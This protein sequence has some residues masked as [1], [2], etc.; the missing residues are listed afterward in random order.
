MKQPRTSDFRLARIFLRIAVCLTALASAVA[1]QET[2]LHTFG[3]SSTDGDVPLAGLVSDASGNL[4]GTTD[5]GGAPDVGTVFELVRSNGGTW[6]EKLIHVFNSNGRDGNAPQATL[7]FDKAGNLYGTTGSGGLYGHGT[8]FEL[9]PDTNGTWTEK[10]L[11]NFSGKDGVL[12]RASLIFDK[13]GNLYGTTDQGG[14]TISSSLCSP[15]GCGTVFEL[16]HR[17]DGS[18]AEKVLHNFDFNGI[19]GFAPVAS[20]AFDSAG[21]LYGTAEEGGA[22]NFGILFELTPKPHGEWTETILHNFNQDGTDGIF[23]G[24]GLFFDASGN[25]Y[26]TTSGGGPGGGGT[27]FE[28]SPGSNGTWT[29]TFLH[30]FGFGTDG[31]VPWGNLTLDA[32]G[33]VYGVGQGG[34]AYSSGTAFQLSPSSSGWTETILHSFGNGLDGQFPNGSMVR[35]SAGNLYGTTQSGGA[36]Q[37]CVSENCGTVFEITP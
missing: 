3:L 30:D 36:G 11:H 21:N 28:F 34:G 9:S 24:S 35:D 13:A 29:E 12:P 14:S 15:Q 18:W 1:Q 16:K 23:P 6:N 17:A 27:A 25:L 26:G 22:Y 2:V 31:S 10:T 5:T 37:S 33:N 8:V 32:N 20:V 19:D 7:I 4:Y